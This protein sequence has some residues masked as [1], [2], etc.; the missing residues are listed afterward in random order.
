MLIGVYAW[1]YQKKLA[2]GAIFA[3]IKG[4]WIR[5]FCAAIAGLKGGAAAAAAR[6]V[7]VDDLQPGVGQVIRVL[8][9]DAVEEPQALRI[10]IHRRP[11]PAEHGVT[12][13]AVI[14]LHRILHPGA[15]TPLD[16]QPQTITLLRCPVCRQDLLKVFDGVLVNRNHVEN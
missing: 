11:L 1:I 7:R 10:H 2:S 16:Q 12:I 6:R 15:A 14:D 3:R 9:L 8:Q 4:F 5:R 13:L